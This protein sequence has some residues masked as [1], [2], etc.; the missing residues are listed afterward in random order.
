M[1]A[2]D[3][4]ALAEAET[5]KIYFSGSISLQK[6]NELV[7]AIDDLNVNY[8]ALKKIYLY[9]NSGGGE[10]SSG[11]AGYWAIKSSNIPIT[12]V[13]I[14]TVASA[15]TMLFCGSRERESL[16]GAVFIVHPPSIELK[17]SSYQ[18]DDLALMTQG[19]QTARKFF[20]DIYRECANFSDDELSSFLHSENTRKLLITEEARERKMINGIADGIVK[21]PIAVYIFD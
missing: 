16:N 8:K 20:S 6:I 5:A 12:T 13:N 3:P 17:A 4:K 14:A 18:P 19:L 10:M 11:Y 1:K 2:S 21:T 7:A 15:A 9:I